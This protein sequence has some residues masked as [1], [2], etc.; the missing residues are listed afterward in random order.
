MSLRSVEINKEEDKVS[1]EKETLYSA[2][3][4]SKDLTSYIQYSL[5]A[6]D[7]AGRL[8]AIQNDVDDRWVG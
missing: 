4:K 8:E 1:M 5:K 6:G 3:I 7:S 2:Y